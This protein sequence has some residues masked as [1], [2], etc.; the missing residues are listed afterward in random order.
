LVQPLAF[1]FGGY[2]PP[3]RRGHLPLADLTVLL[4]PNDAG[5]SRTLG[6]LAALL[7]GG[8]PARGAAVIA[9]CGPDERALLGALLRTS[10]LADD[11]AALVIVELADGGWQLSPASFERCY[12]A[13][14][15]GAEG[16]PGWAQPDTPMALGDPLAVG[17]GLVP[18]AIILPAS[19][20][21]LRA[22]LE[23]VVATVVMVLAGHRG[24]TNGWLLTSDAGRTARVH[25]LAA[26][27]TRRFGREVT[28]AL[29]GFISRKYELVCE[30][31][32]LVDWP[33]AGRSRVMLRSTRDGAL[34]A[35][36][37]AAAGFRIWI[38]L[39]LCETL[40]RLERQ[41]AAVRFSTS[42]ETRGD[43][44]EIAWDAGALD[45]LTSSLA[46]DAATH[47]PQV[48]EGVLDAL[49]PWVYLIDEPEQH[50]HPALIRRA[51]RWLA[52]AM[53]TRGAHAVAVTHSADFLA[54]DSGAFLV[55]VERGEHQ[56]H[57][58]PFDFA[59]L[60]ATDRIAAEMGFDRGELLTRVRVVL[61]VEGAMDRVVLDELF[62][63][64]LSRK[65]I[66]LGVFGGVANVNDVLEHPVVRYTAAH[67]AVLVDAVA[68]DEARRIRDDPELRRSL[69]TGTGERP[70]LAR[71][72]EAARQRDLVVEPFGI[73]ARDIFMVL[74]D[75]P[76]REIAP[77]WPGQ[78][79]AEKLWLQYRQSGGRKGFKRYYKDR[80]DL[81][82]SIRTCR[83]TARRMAQNASRPRELVALVDELERLGS[84]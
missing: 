77:R 38:Q 56:T 76:L 16:L 12:S 54:E 59:T 21:A 11:G 60:V 43:L 49:R 82:V 15:L 53:R 8:A 42:P 44:T 22:R 29:P 18:R 83:Q 47:P 64:E 28:A 70:A 51:A 40:R 48:L 1:V 80:W 26:A 67:I 30:V 37:D 6:A 57:Y 46:R 2:P 45:H 79:E 74:D 34:F 72:I 68:L 84:T 41:L 35:V 66:A 19:F 10:G 71:V 14:D 33:R 24:D 75:E 5:K 20:E 32:R 78:R 65:G 23:E 69:L 7:E 52:N 58:R 17:L 25:P 50:L 62:G 27:V 3:L 73:E 55:Y 61:Y 4:G 13:A 9:E 39:A 81:P 36:D 63:A 31:P